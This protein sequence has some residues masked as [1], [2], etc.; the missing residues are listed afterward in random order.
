MSLVVGLG[1]PGADYAS[2]R[3]NVGFMVVEAFAAAHRIALKKTGSHARVGRGVVNGKD[4]WVAEPLTFMN[5][6]GGAVRLLL[7][8]SGGDVASLLVIHDDLDLPLGQLRFKRRGGP[9]GHNGIRSIIEVLGGND[10]LRLKVGIGRPAGSTEVTDHV[11]DAFMPAERATVD[12]M[13]ERARDAVEMLL[14]DGVTAAM[15]RFHAT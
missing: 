9:G 1:N 14:T 3:H 2:T 11:L 6:S 15:N 5:R 12:S 4:V 7:Q 13:I 8:E 10:F